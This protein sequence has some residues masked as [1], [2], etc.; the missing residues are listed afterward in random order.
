ME[1]QEVR[2]STAKALS[3]VKS[4]ELVDEALSKFAVHFTVHKEGE[5]S[6]EEDKWSKER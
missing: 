6:W 2:A 3:Y 1:A 4:W 5:S